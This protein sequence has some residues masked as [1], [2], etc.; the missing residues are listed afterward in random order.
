MRYV[1]Y[2]DLK[3]EKLLGVKKA[4]IFPRYR[5]STGT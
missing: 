3:N 5:P 1:G 4:R 2:I